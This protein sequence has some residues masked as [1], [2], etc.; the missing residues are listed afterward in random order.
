M[1]NTALNKLIEIFKAP[2]HDLKLN[3]EIFGQFDT[4]KVAKELYLEK[5][6]AEKEF[7]W[8]LTS[9]CLTP[10]LKHSH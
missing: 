5:V 3:T 10:A 4:D 1:S 8:T 6:G 9:L 7:E 2:Q